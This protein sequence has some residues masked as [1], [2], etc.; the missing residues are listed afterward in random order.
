MGLTGRRLLKSGES[1]VRLHG[2]QVNREGFPGFTRFPG[3]VVIGSPLQF[4]R[5]ASKSRQ[6][7]V[8]II[9]PIVV[10]A[11][12]FL[13]CW[14]AGTAFAKNCDPLTMLQLAIPQIGEQGSKCESLPFWGDLASITLT[15]TAALSIAV[16]FVL[17]A[18]L[19]RLGEKLT[20]SGLVVDTSELRSELEGH[21]LRWKCH[22]VLRIVLLLVCLLGSVFFYIRTHDRSQVFVGLSRQTSG[23][24]S[25]ESFENTWWMNFENH[26]YITSAWLL[27]GAIGGYYAVK[28]GALYLYLVREIRKTDWEFQ[29]VPA[30]RDENFGWA[31]VGEIINIVYV[32]FVNFAFASAVL[33]YVMGSERGGNWPEFAILVL[34]VLALL[35]SAVALG[36]LIKF[37]VKNHRG[38]ID[39]EKM[40][41]LENASDPTEVESAAYWMAYGTHL[42][43]APQSYP[44]RSRLKPLLALAPG[45]FALSRVFAE[46]RK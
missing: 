23:H 24:T 2:G 31:P 35:F 10:T 28:Q 7:A 9:F 8:M 25:A 39:R 30:L 32:G 11:G 29:Y 38:V 13:A 14:S 43:L 12:F 19:Q 27:L 26:R 5:N 46:L 4:L 21:L 45:V 34:G 37:M 22:P 15:I 18:R 3:G 17:V 41:V 40:R 42:H 36:M 44:L 16:H 6:D 20:A 1:A 33:F